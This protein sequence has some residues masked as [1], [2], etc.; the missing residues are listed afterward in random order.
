MRATSTVAEF[1]AKSRWEDCPAEAV[2][3]ARRAIL[4]LLLAG[5][6]AEPGL[7]LGAV[8]KATSTFSGADLSQIVETASDEAIQASLAEGRDVPI[9]QPH[10]RAAL[11]EVKP[12]TLDWLSTA[13]NYARYANE[14]GLYDDVL[15]FLD[16][17][18]RKA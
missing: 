15:R 9:R 18:G 17:H 4:E 8:A 11:D 12:T 16:K 3:A 13:R 10:L 7:D 5:R 1:V 2:D 14:G 6:P